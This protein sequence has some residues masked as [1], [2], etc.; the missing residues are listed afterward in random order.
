MKEEQCHAYIYSFLYQLSTERGIN[1]LVFTQTSDIVDRM[2][3]IDANISYTKNWEIPAKT[4]AID[5]KMGQ[6][7]DMQIK[8]IYNTR[9]DAREY[10]I[11]L[12][13]TVSIDGK[14]KI[15]SDDTM[16]RLLEKAFF[17]P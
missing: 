9:T 15:P 7:D 3:W 10:Q 12:P 16:K 17:T 6:S 14:M 13:N 8:K 4:F 5:F 2:T 11:S 1:D